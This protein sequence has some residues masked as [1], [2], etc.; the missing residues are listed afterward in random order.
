MSGDNEP[1]DLELLDRYRRAS[2]AAPS[3]PSDVVREAILAEGR[4]AAARNTAPS[5][6]QFDTKVPA[7][8]RPRWRYA[9]IGTA[10]AAALAAFLVVPRFLV[11]PRE[12]AVVV[13]NYPRAAESVPLAPAPEAMPAQAAP[14]P[15][16][17]EVPS[18]APPPAVAQNSH[19]L[20]P[21]RRSAPE[22]PAPRAKISSDALVAD[23]SRSPPSAFADATT[24]GRPS[25][26]D[27]LAAQRKSAAAESKSMTSRL[28]SDLRQI[29]VAP[30]P[31]PQPNAVGGAVADQAIAQP[32]APPQPSALLAQ[33][34]DATRTA[35]SEGESNL[36]E[37]IVTQAKAAKR[38]PTPLISA[39]NWGRA[40]KA[41]A[42][43]ESGEGSTTETDAQGRTP[44]LR[45]VE[46]RR[47]DLVQLLLAHG[48]DPNAADE[49]GETPL[50]LARREKLTDIVA[51]LEAAAKASP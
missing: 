31:A 5:A 7:A 15:K 48:A 10:C 35:G 6:H 18:V 2:D 11:Q 47:L 24:A 16:L 32:A 39:V 17:E 43:L 29:T 28:S 25:G 26:S 27:A 30:E 51:L 46:R 34:A 20:E 22:A 23:A 14:A 42:L 44:L 3:Q 38:P 40:E 33:R 36:S 8:N 21:Y 45:A 13:Q 41:Q 1:A 9:A 4:R 12:Q 37:I 19:P 50:S 49:A